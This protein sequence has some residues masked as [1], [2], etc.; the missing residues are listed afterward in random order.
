VG[1]EPWFWCVLE[2]DDSIIRCLFQ[3]KCMESLCCT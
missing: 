1:N 2:K 3:L